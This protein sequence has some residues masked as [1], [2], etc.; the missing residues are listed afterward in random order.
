MV[1]RTGTK[2][3]QKNITELV[4]QMPRL[5]ITIYVIWKSS[6]CLNIF[7]FNQIKGIWEKSL[8]TLTLYF[9]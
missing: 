2:P 7:Y 4:L 5:S 8:P 3:F 6:T 1:D 9:N